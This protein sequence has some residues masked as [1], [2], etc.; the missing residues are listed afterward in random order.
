M[1]PWGSNDTFLLVLAD[2]AN[3]EGQAVYKPRAG[4]APLWDFP[5]GTLYLREYAAY[6]VSKALGWPD[7][8][9][10]VVRDG[11]HG[12]G[13]VQLYI[14]A[15]PARH[16]FAFRHR[17]QPELRRIAL[18]DLLA[19]NA[20]RKGGHCL[21]GIGGRV[22]CI[23]HGLAFHADPKLRTVIWDFCGEPIPEELLAD[24]RTL[25]PRLTPHG[26]LAKA[27]EKLLAPDEL[28]ALR[29]R[30][31]RLLE[32]GVYPHPGPGRYT[33]WPPV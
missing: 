31:D 25:R 26:D 9:P 24:L 12:V 13:S 27:L 1:L 19:N 11:P 3:G 10:T 16:Y 29:R 14:D 32:S 33:P 23:D 7:I 15:D 6:V 30:L 18:F 5:A 17:R 20:D 8:P 28:H 2:A 21:E 4:E 22:W